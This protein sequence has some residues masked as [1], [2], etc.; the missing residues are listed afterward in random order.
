MSDGQVYRASIERRDALDQP[1]GGGEIAG[2]VEYVLDNLR[3]HIEALRELH[4]G[5]RL[6]VHIECEIPEDHPLAGV[7]LKR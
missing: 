7:D 6:S 2:H 3:L 4:P 5:D 1:A